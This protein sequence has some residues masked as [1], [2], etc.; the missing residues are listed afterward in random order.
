[1][2]TEP[3]GKIHIDEQDAS[4][5]KKLGVMRWVLMASMLAAIVVL[6]FIWI[7]GAA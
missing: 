1:M 5:G 4:G 2:S 7:N 6:S 3:D